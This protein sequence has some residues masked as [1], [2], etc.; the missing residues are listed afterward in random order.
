MFKDV[1]KNPSTPFSI[2]ILVAIR[3]ELKKFNEEVIVTKNTG[4][5]G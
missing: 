5:S 2:A 3:E 1:F 4:K